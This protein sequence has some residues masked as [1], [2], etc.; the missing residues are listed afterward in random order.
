MPDFPS[1]DRAK[2]KEMRVTHSAASNKKQR[3]AVLKRDRS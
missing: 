3:E 1:P 2:V